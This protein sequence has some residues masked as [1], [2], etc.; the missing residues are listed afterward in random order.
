PILPRE[1]DVPSLTDE[2]DAQPRAKQ[3]EIIRDAVKQ[4]MPWVNI[5]KGWQGWSEDMNSVFVCV[6]NSEGF[7]AKFDSQVRKAV[8]EFVDSP[9]E[10]NYVDSTSQGRLAI[11]TE[12]TGFPLDA[13]KQVHYDWFRQYETIR[14]D[15][16]QAPLHTQKEWEKFARPTAPDAIEM[17][18]RLN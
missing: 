16:R 7:K 8:S 9:K 5:N 17:R 1:A 2:L 6:R 10:I 4:S 15:G 3:D 13:L 14:E 11:C 18:R 12:L